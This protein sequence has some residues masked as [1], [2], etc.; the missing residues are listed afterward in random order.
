V[1][2]EIAAA[3][4]LLR[5]RGRAE[6]GGWALIPLIALSLL[7]K[8]NH[9][10]ASVLLPALPLV[11]GLGVASLPGRW[12]RRGAAVVVVGLATVQLLARSAPDGPVARALGPVEWQVGDATWGRVFQTSDGDMALAPDPDDRGAARIAASV[13]RAAPAGTCGC[14][15]AVRTRGRGPWSGTNLHLLATH[16]CLP[17]KQGG[18]LDNAAVL[19]VSEDARDAD[20]AALER[21]GLPLVDQVQTGSGLVRVHARPTGWVEGRC[22]R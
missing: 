10:Y 8:K 20:Q 15:L 1:P 19:L 4:W 17:V 12:L 2:V 3:A 9:Y 7:P 11:L 21:M 14:G 18:H 5:G 13:G 22:G 16:P 6:L